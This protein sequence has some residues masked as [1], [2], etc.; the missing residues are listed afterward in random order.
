MADA[1]LSYDG[2]IGGPSL[3]Q[4]LQYL[5]DHPDVVAEYRKKAAVHAQQHYSWDAITDAYE[6]LFYDVLAG[7]RVASFETA[8]SSST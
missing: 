1:A 4:G 5:L 8:V 7:R 3:R 6:A 2:Q